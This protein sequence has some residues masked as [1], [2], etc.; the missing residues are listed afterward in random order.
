MKSIVL[1]VVLAIGLVVA[2]SAHAEPCKRPAAKIV[3]GI[4]LA[5][6]ALMPVFGG[7]YARGASNACYGSAANN[8][9][10]Q[11]MASGGIYG[12]I[13]DG[14]MSLTLLTAGAALYSAGEAPPANLATIRF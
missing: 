10:C 13:G 4:G 11:A 6:L 3:L 5:S 12:M 14:V 2:S 9:G 8:D 1:A 7:L